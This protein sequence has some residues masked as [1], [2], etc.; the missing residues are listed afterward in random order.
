MQRVS[1]IPQMCI[2][3]S[4]IWWVAASSRDETVSTSESIQ[5]MACGLCVAL[6]LATS[7]PSFAAQNSLVLNLPLYLSSFLSPSR[8]TVLGYNGHGTKFQCKHVKIYLGRYPASR[9]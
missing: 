3:M 6:T 1:L 2:L 9:E 4:C 5:S 7:V 8:F